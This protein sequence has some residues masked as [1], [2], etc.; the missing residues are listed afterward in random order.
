MQL[1]SANSPNIPPHSQ[2][3]FLQQRF[4]LSLRCEVAA[5]RA[6]ITVQR[7]TATLSVSKLTKKKL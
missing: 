4:G 7:V 1:N 5:V 3:V 6:V 2:E